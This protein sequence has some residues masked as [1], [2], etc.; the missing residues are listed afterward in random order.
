MNTDNQQQLA[1]DWLPIVPIE[2]QGTIQEQF[3]EFHRRNPHVYRLIYGLARKYKLSGNKRCGMKMLW[4]TLRFNSG[5]ETHG[6]EYKLNNNFTSRYS[7]M[8]LEEPDMHGFF[9]VRTL[10]AK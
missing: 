8:L 10:R 1:F 3:E 6:N 5:V 9:K 2:P 7:R 4:E